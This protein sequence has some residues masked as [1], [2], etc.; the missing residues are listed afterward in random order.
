M[1]SKLLVVTVV[2]AAML[3][4]MAN[5]MAQRDRD[6]RDNRD[7]R[8]S[9]GSQTGGEKPHVFFNGK[10]DASLSSRAVTRGGKVMVPAR[11]FFQRVGG[12]VRQQQGWVPPGSRQPDR[13]R[14]QRW[15]VT[16]RNGRELRYRLGDRLYYYGGQPHYWSV[17]P[18]EEGGELFLALGDLALALG[19]GYDYD[20]GRNYGRVTLCDEGYCPAA[21]ELRLIYPSPSGY[22][23]VRSQTV[24]QGYAPPYAVVRIEVLKAMPFPFRNRDVSTQVTRANRS[25]MFSVLVWLRD[26][27]E[28]KVNVDLLD[29]YGNLVTRQ[30]ARFYVR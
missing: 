28:Y 23:S 18:Y 2:C 4:F 17:E 3:V 13:D 8:G 9:H 27:G 21:G 6:R 29:G 20:S 1:K 19:G 14:Q 30:S 11:P 7:N 5:A 15:Y 10:E 24:I 12:D 26:D 22:Y 16:Q 25:G